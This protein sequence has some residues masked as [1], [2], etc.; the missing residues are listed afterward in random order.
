MSVADT[1]KPVV[2]RLDGEGEGPLEVGSQGVP[3]GRVPG[4][5]AEAP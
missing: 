2:G 5:G 4:H 1:W 3:R